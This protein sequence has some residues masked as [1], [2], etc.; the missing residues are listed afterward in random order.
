MTTATRRPSSPAALLTLARRPET[1][2]DNWEHRS[3]CYNRPE[4]WWDG[5]DR[6]LTEKA[7]AVCLSC[8]VLAECLGEKMRQEKTQTWSRSSVRGGL[9]GPE[10][11]QLAM[12][13]YIEG[14][15]DAE[16]ARLLAL[17]AGAYGVPVAEVVEESVS[18]STILLAA[19]MAGEDVPDRGRVKIPR[20]TATERAFQHA[21]QIMQ[22]R[23]E[24]VSR[25][26]ICARLR[27]GRTAIDTVIRT[28]RSLMG[29]SVKRPDPVDEVDQAD[30]ND[31]LNGQPVRLTHEQ[32]L[33]AVVEG[34][35][36]GMRYPDIDRAQSLSRDTTAQFVS[37][38]RKRYK[39]D[40]REFPI[41]PMSARRLT[42]TDEEVLAIRVEYASGG[43]RDMDLALKY[44]VSRNVISHVVSG[45]NYKDVGGPIRSGKTE[46]AKQA[47]REW[48]AGHTVNSRAAI[49][50]NE[51]GEA[52]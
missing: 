16:E 12:D 11:T 23:D 2:T 15:Y 9:T 35:R 4:S 50:Q 30:V 37:R 39:K 1:L 3:A 6:N 32:K 43:V 20:D 29:E 52:A 8:P 38:M 45:R 10:R 27:M 36:R 24:G 13:E 7:R 44:G 48:G 47:S 49:R 25:R 34:L 42:F 31:Y 41:T 21:D 17:E 40:G 18:Q 51:M 14:P 28:Y 5:D 33:A 22:W 19:R 26:D 46:Q